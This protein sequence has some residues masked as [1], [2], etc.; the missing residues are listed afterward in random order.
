MEKE[1]GKE[2]IVIHNI[3]KL[4]KYDLL[5]SIA[6]KFF[7]LKIFEY[8]VRPTNPLAMHD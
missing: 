5:V 8:N 2:I 3:F 4:I 6:T 7:S 1:N